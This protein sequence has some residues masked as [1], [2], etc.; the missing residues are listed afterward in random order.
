MM[1][2]T[3]ISLRRTDTAAVEITA[4]PPGAGPPANRIATRLIFEG[5]FGGRANVLDIEKT[6]EAIINQKQ[7]CVPN[8]RFYRVFRGEPRHARTVAEL[9]HLCP[10]TGAHPPFGH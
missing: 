10:R 1:P 3:S 7:D 4:L 9:S 6:P 2:T 8:P 5:F